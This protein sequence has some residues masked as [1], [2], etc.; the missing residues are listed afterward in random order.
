MNILYVVFILMIC[1]PQLFCAMSNADQSHSSSIKPTKTTETNKTLVSDQSCPCCSSGLPSRQYS[2]QFLL[3]L[4]PIQEAN[5]QQAN[6]LAAKI[7]LIIPPSPA[8]KEDKNN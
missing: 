7:N 6:A 2:R 1:L 3:S 8:S 5:E 4:K